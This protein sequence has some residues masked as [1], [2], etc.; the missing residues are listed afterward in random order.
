MVWLS[1]IFLTLSACSSESVEDTEI[2]RSAK[3]P[4]SAEIASPSESAPLPSRVY[5]KAG[6]L[7]QLLVLYKDTLDY[8]GAKDGDS[9][10]AYE[11]VKALKENAGRLLG[12][13]SKSLVILTDPDKKTG[14]F[15]NVVIFVEPDGR[16]HFVDRKGKRFS[17]HLKDR[18]IGGTISDGAGH[19]GLFTVFYGKPGDADF[20]SAY[21]GTMKLKVLSFNHD[22]ESGNITGKIQMP[23][24]KTLTVTRQGKDEQHFA[25]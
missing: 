24:G 14:W 5:P 13:E 8:L 6:S 21:W 11:G 10:A 22:R 4:E 17:E 1:L 16:A 12:I 2:R 23:N 7:E 20:Y 9:N 18:V 15:G 25:H 3:R 19:S